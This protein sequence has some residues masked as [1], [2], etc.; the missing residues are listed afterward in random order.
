[1]QGRQNWF[2][3]GLL[4]L[5]LVSLGIASISFIGTSD[6]S[7]EASEVVESNDP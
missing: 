2:I 3:A 5:A 7:D 1:M 6:A 4:A